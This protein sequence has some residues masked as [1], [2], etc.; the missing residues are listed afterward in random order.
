MTLLFGFV[1]FILFALLSRLSADLALWLAFAAS[2][3]VTI[4]DFVES[5]SLRLLDG[6]SFA[7][8]GL[9]ALIRGFVMPELSLAI[10]RTV[11]DAVLC[12]AIFA[13][14]IRGRPFSLQY[15]NRD[16]HTDW[17][18]PA[19]LRVNQRISLVWAI[20]FGA[21]TLADGAV[22][23]LAFPFYLGIGVSVVALAAGITFT[24]LYPALAA[25]RLAR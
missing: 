10:V 11:V 25:N 22:A 21:M 4:R 14:L 23:F 9:L 1:P 12:L 6:T 20:A 13:S 8:F 2:F 3:V 7:L 15:A 19:F 5:P 16:T 18:L 17:P 24:L